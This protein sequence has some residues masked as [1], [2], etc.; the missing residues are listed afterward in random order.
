MIVE[1]SE[2]SIHHGAIRGPELC[3]PPQ[4]RRYPPP[5][6]P[7]AMVD[8]LFVTFLALLLIT[9]SAHAQVSGPNCS[10]PSMAWSFN[11]LSQGPCMVA[12]FLGAVC[13]N[14]KFEIP[15]LLPQNSYTGPSGLDDG[16]SCKCNTV[17][18]SLLS[19]CAACQEGSWITYPA[20]ITNCTSVSAA[21]TFSEPIPIGSRVPN[22][23][24]LDPT[25]ASDDKWNASAAQLAGDSPEITGSASNVPTSTKNSQSTFTP[26]TTSP[27]SNS[28]NSSS[29]GGAIAGGVT[30][31]IAG[32]ALIAVVVAWITVRRRRA[33]SALSAVA[34]YDQSD[35]GHGAILYPTVASAP[36]L[37]DPSDPS[38]YP[39]QAP[40]SIIRTTNYGSQ[41]A[42]SK[43]SLRLAR[44]AFTG[45][46]EV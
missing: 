26:Q 28:S 37:Y 30:G 44:Q 7:H 46:P 38:T 8:S 9:G 13:N 27:S 39:P 12:A 4:Y 32:A 21:G 1:D 18:Y 29:K 20:W 3:F 6:H 5:Y 23:A 16:D 22:W 43:S 36:R 33:R 35:M 25:R 19:A 42:D 14:G 15:A 40:S 17:T 24:Y 41:F 2:H 31:G 10:D 11:S 34:F 45:L